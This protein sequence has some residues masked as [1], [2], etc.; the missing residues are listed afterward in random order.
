MDNFIDV[1]INFKLTLYDK[2]YCRFNQTF[3]ALD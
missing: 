1:N 2:H 3:S